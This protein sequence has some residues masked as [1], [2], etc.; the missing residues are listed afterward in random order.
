MTDPNTATGARDG[1]LRRVRDAFRHVLCRAAAEAAHAERV[2]WGV[3]PVGDMAFDAR[4]TSTLPSVTVAFAL[5]GPEGDGPVDV[6]VVEVG[7]GVSFPVAMIGADGGGLDR[8]LR[9]LEAA[10]HWIVL[11]LRH[12]LQAAVD[13]RTLSTPGLDRLSKAV[14]DGSLRA[15]PLVR[16]IVGIA[17]VAG[18]FV[19]GGMAA[20]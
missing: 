7:T 18:A 14:A 15:S 3:H 6:T 11:H 20:E 16:A 5:T 4:F 8:A 19:L 12:R 2:D 1:A 13:A 17:A 9:R 10:E